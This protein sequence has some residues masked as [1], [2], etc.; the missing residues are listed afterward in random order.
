M[1]NKPYSVNSL[2]KSLRNFVVIV[3]KINAIVRTG[4]ATVQFSQLRGNHLSE[5]CIRSNVAS[6]VDFAILHFFS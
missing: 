5:A 6:G 2:A 1:A 3:W 4:I